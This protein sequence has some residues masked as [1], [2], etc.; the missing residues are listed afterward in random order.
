[1]PARKSHRQSETRAV[2]NRRVKSITRT[3]MN[4]AFLTLRSGDAESAETAV[5]DASAVLDRGVQKGILHKNNASR[6]K[7]RIAA[8]LN[9]VRKAAAA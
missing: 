2:R 5:R 3:V 7:S 8:R 4:K 1:L 6:R 9:Q